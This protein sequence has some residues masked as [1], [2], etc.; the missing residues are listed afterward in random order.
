MKRLLIVAILL[1]W[2]FIEHPTSSAEP[3]S[4]SGQQ[5]E[6]QL[7]YPSPANVWT[8]ALPIGNG[9]MGA[10]IFGGTEHARIQFN[11]DTL[12][13]GGPHNYAHEGA[14]DHLETIRS[15][16][17]SGKQDEAEQLAS[18]HF[19]SVPLRQMSYQPFGNIVL[20]F[21][22]HDQPTDYRRSLDLESAV[23]KTTYRVDGVTYTR[24][25]F[26]SYPD[27]AIVVT[28]SCDDPGGLNFSAALSSPQDEV[29]IRK[30]NDRTL[31]LTGRVHDKQ[32]RSGKAIQSHMTLAA[33]LSVLQTDGEVVATPES[34]TVANATQATLV[35]TAATN[36]LAFD[37]LSGNPLQRSAQD[38]ERVTEVSYPELKERHIE[39]YQNL[40]KRVTL[41][42]GSAGR[43]D[44]PTDE[45]VLKHQEKVDPGLEAL[46]FQYGRYL[47]IASSRPGCQPANLQGLWNDQLQPS[48]DS[49]Y[50]VN[51][52]AEMNYWPAEACNLSECADPLFAALEEIAES[53]AK[54]AKTH[55]NAPG[56]VLHHNFDIW[57][58]TAPINASNH[59]IWP[60]GGAWLCQH[61]WWHYQYSQDQD[62]LG[63][64]AYPLMKGASEFFVDYLVEYS[65][66]GESW[67]IS[68]PS[69]SPEQGG[70]VM[71]PTMDH[72]IIRCLFNNTAE[73]ARILSVD[74]DFRD[75]L[76]EMSQQIA[77][78]QI[79]KHGQLQEWLE[80][81]DDPMNRHRHV[82]HLWGVFPGS[83]IG[84]DTP[85]LFEAA[86][87]S[88]EFRGDGGTGWSLA[89]KINLWSRLKDGDRAYKLLHNLLRLTNSPRTDYRGGGV[90]P[91]LFD[92]HPP[93]QIDGNFG[94]TN[95]IC[96]ML[97]QS[98]RKT[99]AGHWIVDLLPAL[100]KSWPEGR[101]T[102]LRARG[103]IELDFAWKNSKVTSIT[104]SSKV[105]AECQIHTGGKQID[106]QI[107]PGDSVQLNEF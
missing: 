84:A 87:R 105:G 103:G 18:R 20:N 66:K 22:G 94:A 90:Y 68:G 50:T 54:T 91:N 43:N 38:L 42:L 97:L 11:E 61:L 19:M 30:Q 79:G 88:L 41:D 74:P 64:V 45:R 14:A 70:L 92:A 51:I 6:L 73:A 52:N 86:K 107:A 24:E 62:F 17:F 56:W 49:K 46:L 31:E 55:Y 25:Y 104:I 82:S 102:G 4:S 69:N 83:E 47:M 106:V 37:D 89:W 67:L 35:L 95:G 93:F 96:Q 3:Q 44:L 21:P 15:L 40:F 75:R 101:A 59:G 32:L 26:A 81:I 12:W 72:Q 57:R 34:I 71:G 80:D 100:P 76:L 48:W 98:H 23:A 28:V 2:V 1:F 77:P 29:K 85:E 36:L 78:N 63:N 16:L 33:H 53:G 13:T 60:A 9:R 7:W 65:L 5:H 39:D 8:E 58:G 10:M 27:R 99:E